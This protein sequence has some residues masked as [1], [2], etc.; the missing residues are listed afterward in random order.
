MHAASDRGTQIQLTARTG[1]CLALALSATALLGSCGS[2]SSDSPGLNGGRQSAPSTVRPGPTGPAVSIIH[3]SGLPVPQLQG[4]AG[5]NSQLSAIGSKL[6]GT[7]TVSA[8]RDDTRVASFLWSCGG[9]DTA[10]T[11]DLT[12]NRQLSL[13][14]LLQGDYTSYLSSTAVTQMQANGDAKASASDFSVWYVTPE[15]LV[16][17]FPAGTVSFPI[18]S[19][20]TYLRP[21]GP[22]S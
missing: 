14:D 11:F 8:E 1:A 10:A 16:V 4:K 22:L 9:H 12:R 5:V 21:G 19:L 20:T 13:D 17:V 2:S 6:S 3:V 15:S 18:S 7:C